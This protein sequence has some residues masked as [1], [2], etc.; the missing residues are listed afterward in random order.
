VKVKGVERESYG[1]RLGRNG[2]SK[3]EDEKEVADEEEEANVRSNVKV[4]T[5]FHSF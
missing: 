4:R 3:E 5:L 1:E 2:A